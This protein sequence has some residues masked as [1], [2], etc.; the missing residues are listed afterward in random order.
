MPSPSSAHAAIAAD[1][2]R[3]P[4]GEV[5]TALIEQYGIDG[6]LTPLVSER[7]Q[8]FQVTTPRGRQY[9]AKVASAGES[10][11]AAAFQV[12]ALEHLGAN[13]RVR[14]PRLQRTLEAEATGR[15]HYDGQSFGLRVVSYLDGDLLAGMD[16]DP[17]VAA[18]L[19]AHLAELDCALAGFTHEGQNQEL[20]WDLQRLPE[21]RGLLSHIDDAALRE[22]VVRVVDDFVAAVQPCLGEL[23]TQ[24][25][26]GDA[27]P[28]NVVMDPGGRRP[29]GFIDFGDMVSAPLVFEVA[30]AAAYLR[31]DGDDPLALIAPFVAAYQ[32]RLPLRDIERALLFDLVRARL[33]TTIT[34]LF[35]RLG[36]R[37]AGDAYRQKTLCTESGAIR[38]LEALDTLGNR[39]FARRI[40]NM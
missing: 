2:P 11:L 8:N 34:I 26:H 21:L 36:A 38:F 14:A 35:W 5:A 30:I 12:A 16:I 18:D 28:E 31:T 25:I 19:G 37:R 33:A 20:L 39:Q 40:E 7:D 15:I 17:A 22:R 32:R 24:V 10:A 27:N 29:P 1:P 9:V 4:A 3:L 6:S 23:R 13:R